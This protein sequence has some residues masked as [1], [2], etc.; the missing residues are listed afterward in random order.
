MVGEWMAGGQIAAR[1][2]LRLFLRESHSGHLWIRE[3]DI[4]QRAIIDA[5]RPVGIGQIMSRDFS[6]LHGNMND[7]MRSS[8]VA[9][10]VNMRN[11]GLHLRVGQ[12]SALFGGN[13]SFG[14][15]QRSDVG[16]AT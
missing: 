11:I 16:C 9:G 13:A 12:D 4:N 15:I 2:F 7:F 6:L 3:N 10:G 1:K 8:A 5:P 14:E